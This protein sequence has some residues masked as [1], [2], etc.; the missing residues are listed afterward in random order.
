MMGASP[1]PVPSVTGTPSGPGSDRLAIHFIADAH[2]GVESESREAKKAADLIALLGYLKS[3]S[4]LLYLVGDLFDFW[5]EYPWA[6][7]RDHAEV[8]DALRRLVD[9]GTRVEFL[10]GNHDYWAGRRFE[11][12]TGATVHRTPIST[13]HF[14]KRVFI[15]HGDGL[16]KGDLGY[17]MLKAVLRSPVAIAAFTL[18]PPRAGSAIGRWASNLSEVTE[19]RIAHAVPPMTVF[20]NGLLSREY[21]VAVVA[22]IHKQMMWKVGDRTAVI[23]GDWMAHRSVIEMTERGLRPL[24]WSGGTLVEESSG[25]F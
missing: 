2:L 6:R 15:A 10:G 23:V 18:I 5:F 11:A 20:L 13:T 22:H 17:R 16:P 25:R 1:G 12:L 8:T 4:S 3:R 9:S 19:E 7:P 14:G 24:M 21:D